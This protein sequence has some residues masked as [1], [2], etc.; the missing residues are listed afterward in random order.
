VK[1][2]RRAEERGERSS[3]KFLRLLGL[4]PRAILEPKLRSPCGSLQAG[5]ASDELELRGV[6]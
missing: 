4:V 6:L 5:D 1:L 3:V 2:L